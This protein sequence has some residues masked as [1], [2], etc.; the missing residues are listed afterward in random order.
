[1]VPKNGIGSRNGIE[2]S[3]LY[4]ISLVLQMERGNGNVTHFPEELLNMS[5]LCSHFRHSHPQ[6]TTA[7]SGDGRP[8][9]RSH[10]PLPI[11]DFGMI[12]TWRT[13][14]VPKLSFFAL[15]WVLLAVGEEVSIVLGFLLVSPN[16]AENLVQSLVQ[17][18]LWALLL[19]SSCFLYLLD[20]TYTMLCFLWRCSALFS[21]L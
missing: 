17:P 9:K 5:F 20:S 12:S 18:S 8:M 1:M 11:H 10:A 15:F 14:F 19:L 21:W 6:N 16:K 4:I 7:P 13:F 2:S 3:Q